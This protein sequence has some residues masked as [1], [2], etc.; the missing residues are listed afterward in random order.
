ME[1][2]PL[3]GFLGAGASEA[4]ET[5]ARTRTPLLRASLSERQGGRS[6]KRSSRA[7]SSFSNARSKTMMTATPRTTATRTL[8]RPFT[9]RS[10][11]R[12]LCWRATCSIRLLMSRQAASTR[13]L[14][15]GCARGPSGPPLTGALSRER[16]ASALLPAFGQA[17]RSNPLRPRTRLQPRSPYF[18]GL[19]E[20]TAGDRFLLVTASNGRARLTVV[21]P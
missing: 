4:N 15:S 12:L 8:R 19:A 1:P 11:S 17:L 18:T 14:Q 9:R 3:G 7:Q 16:G 21:R 20:V 6:T 2:V 10:R 5:V 13:R